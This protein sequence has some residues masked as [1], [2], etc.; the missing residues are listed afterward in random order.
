MPRFEVLQEGDTVR[1]VASDG[2]ILS[3]EVVKIT[4][5]NVGIVN[6]HVKGDTAKRVREFGG[7]VRFELSVIFDGGKKPKP[8]TWHY[9]DI[10]FY[11][12]LANGPHLPEEWH[13]QDQ[14]NE[15]A[16]ASLPPIIRAAG[17]SVY[18][19]RRGE[20]GQGVE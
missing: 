3:A 13:G 8:G 11:S 10:P 16:P 15:T 12:S 17:D 4:N 14:P 18:T 7:P 5:R 19:E 1:F 2:E 6:L 9:R 20:M